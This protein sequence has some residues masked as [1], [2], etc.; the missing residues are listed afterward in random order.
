MMRF[1]VL[2]LCLSLAGC[3]MQ[4][5]MPPRTSLQ[6]REIQSRDFDTANSTLVMK[7]L[8]NVLQDEGF[9]TR[10]AVTDLGLITATREANTSDTSAMV[11]GSIIM[12]ND[13]TWPQT[14]IVEATANVS[15][16]GS[17]RT[18]VRLSFMEKQLDNR[19]GVFRVREIQDPLF[20][21]NFFTKVDKGLFIERSGI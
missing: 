21:K 20:Y 11:F 19:G 4:P 3:M 9:V 8:L 10:N 16:Y 6:V 7:A 15:P 1:V 12:G 13:A 17:S 18:R 5:A 2:G 14:N